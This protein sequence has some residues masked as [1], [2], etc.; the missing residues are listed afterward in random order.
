MEVHEPKAPWGGS[1]TEK[2]LQAFIKY[3]KAYLTIMNKHPWKTIYFDGFA[4]SG[5]R[6][7]ETSDLAV[8]LSI[9]PQEEKV[10]QGAAERV[11][12][13]EGYSFDYYYFIDQDKDAID[14]LEAYLKSLPQSKGKTLRFLRGD[15]NEY[16][17][18][19][20]Q[21]LKK[22]PSY[23]ALVFL[24]PFGMQI[25]WDAISNLK[26]T[27]SDIWILV[28]TGVIINR[29]LDRRGTLKNIKKLERFFGMEEAKIRDYFYKTERRPTLFG[30]TE[31]S[32][33]VSNAVE[34]IANLYIKRL[35]EVWSHVSPTP[36]RLLNS[37]NF[38]IF[39]FV[40]ASNNTTALKIASQIIDKS[41]RP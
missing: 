8:Q 21:T 14:S 26:G 28:P 27:R 34:Q 37:K 12:D 20:A 17:D 39:H 40:F 10:Y 19:L 22:T 36:L 38:P 41:K 35:E 3:V 5:D 13:I 32:S 6:T 24:D 2:K 30:E 7:G 4:G 25:N 23:A 15:C 29:L 31:T 9:L 1:W 11:L 33:K 16:L 18:K